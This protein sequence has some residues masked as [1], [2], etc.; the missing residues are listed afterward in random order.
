MKARILTDQNETERHLLFW[1]PGCEEAHSFRVAGPEGRP[2]WT[3]DG[4]LESPTCDPSLR[5]YTYD[6]QSGRGDITKCHLNL[7]AGKLVYHGDSPHALK[8][9]TVD[10]P[11]LPADWSGK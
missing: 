6:K 7:T 3:W 4:N 11:D 9:Q 8:G 10:L 2:R 5:V 1:C